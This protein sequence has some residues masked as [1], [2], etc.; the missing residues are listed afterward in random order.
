MIAMLFA[1]LPWA[2]LG[3]CLA[4]CLVVSALGF[5]RTDWF[6]SIGYGFSVAAQALLLGLFYSGTLSFW[7][8]V[9]LLLLCAYGLR[10]A[11]YLIA[12]ERAPSYG[13]ELASSRQR[14]A[15]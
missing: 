10:L 7:P 1:N 9:Q 2:A 8:L 11:L 6:I 14:S 12:R 13:T 5:L 15:G 3:A 4:L